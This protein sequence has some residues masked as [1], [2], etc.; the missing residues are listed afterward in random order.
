MH[1]WP[2]LP[3][4]TVAS[5]PGTILAGAI[6]FEA[7]VR[8]RGGHAAMP[9]LTVDPVVAAAA[10]VG[11]LQALVARETSPFDS[12]VVSVTRLQAGEGFNVI[13][14]QGGCEG[15]RVE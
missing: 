10:G 7:T 4:G 11:A 14:D 8:G 1:V 12:A 9:H 15:S 2:M 3:T 6:Q 5:R 13:P